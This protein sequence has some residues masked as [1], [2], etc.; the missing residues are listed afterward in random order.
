[1]L[2]DEAD[3]GLRIAPAED[4]GG[5]ERAAI[6][7]DDFPVR[8][9]PKASLHILRARPAQD[10]ARASQDRNV[11]CH[12]GMVESRWVAFKQRTSCAASRLP[13]AAGRRRA[14]NRMAARDHSP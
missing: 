14:A 6:G 3:L 7:L 5:I 8:P 11:D 13:M 4:G 1:M 10:E 12:P 9:Q 2:R